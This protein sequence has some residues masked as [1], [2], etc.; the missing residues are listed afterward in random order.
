[1]ALQ[2][3]TFV[4]ERTVHFRCGLLACGA[5][6]GRLIPIDRG[7]THMV[8]MVAGF[9]QES[10]GLVAL[11]R[12]V[13]KQWRLAQNRGAAWIGV[14]GKGEKGWREP[15]WKPAPR[16]FFLPRG[17]KST[18]VTRKLDGAGART[19]AEARFGPIRPDRDARVMDPARGRT[20]PRILL[21]PPEQFRFRCPVCGFINQVDPPPCGPE[22]PCRLLDL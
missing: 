2:A 16:E 9:G 10:D 8:E 17:R 18:R 19:D 20:N 1:M 4:S 15:G 11:T 12:R 21:L 6:V 13:E 3:R 22:C 14:G 7:R 5:Y